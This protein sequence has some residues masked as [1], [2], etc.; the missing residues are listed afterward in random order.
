MTA[1]KIAHYKVRPTKI[2]KT[3]TNLCLYCE[4]VAYDVM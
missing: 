1:D 3:I 4:T 2:V